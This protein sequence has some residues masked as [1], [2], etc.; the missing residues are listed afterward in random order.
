MNTILN[1]VRMLLPFVIALLPVL[2]CQKTNSN[3]NTTPQGSTPVSPTP[4]VVTPPSITK[5]SPD[6]AAYNATVTVYGTGFSDTLANDA[7]KINGIAVPITKVTADSLVLTVPLGVGSGP[8]VL[9]VD[10]T[11][12]NGPSFTYL[13][14]ATVSTLA[15]GGTSGNGLFLDG[16]GAS[17]E[18][19]EPYGVAVDKQ[20]NVYVADDANSRVR[21]I[22][23]AGVVSTLA[24]N[25][26]SGY[27]NGPG[28]GS[29]LSL[30]RGVAIDGQG[31][32]Y[33]TDNG[34]VRIRMI[35]SSDVV[36]TFAG[37]GFFGSV[38]GPGATASFTAPYGV[39]VDSAG[40]IYIADAGNQLIR[41]ITSGDVVS[42]LAGNTGNGSGGY[43]DASTGAAAWFSSPQ[44]LAIDSK[45]NIYVA[46]AG[47]NRIRTISPTGAV[48]TV[49]G[50]G[51]ANFKD[52]ATA[53]SAEFNL[54]SGIAVDT[55]GNLYVADQS[56]NRIRMI[57]AAGAVSTLAGDGTANFKDGP[58]L[59]AEFNGPSGIAI[60]QQG[61]LYV[62]DQY[63][64][65][66]RKITM[67]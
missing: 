49:A 2:A 22:T 8:V 14:T 31:N 54:P 59:S 26:Y 32:I 53:L 17:A 38:N 20:G 30:P 25:G 10:G 43:Q 46:D 37:T 51:N 1:A 9:T 6:T 12:V 15:G 56:N 35:N 61:N 67:Q 44:G 21:L 39:M 50:D 47:N 29:E 42:T 40:N 62:A 57:S 28:N 65:R 18:F 33:V 58:G 34:N 16:P 24:G 60:D 52:A 45:G 23:P 19:R 63:N 36:S 3:S 11:N 4:P 7:L 64:N 41:K 13:L 55:K 27:I 66:I 5:V 48:T